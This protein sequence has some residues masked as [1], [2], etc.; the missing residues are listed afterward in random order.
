ML[1]EDPA[2]SLVVF[3]GDNIYPRGLPDSTSAGFAEAARRLDTQVEVPL[4]R[5]VRG[6][7]VPGNHDWDRFGPDGWNAIRRQGARV[8]RLGRGLVR[9][10]P[11]DGCPG[12]AVVDEGTWLRLVLVDTQWWLHG[13]EKPKGARSLCQS[14]DDVA[15]QDALRSAMLSA[16]ERRVVV[17]GHHPLAS[18]GEHGGFFDWKD[19]LFPLR[20]FRPWLLI[21]FP[22]IGSAYPVARGF[23]ISSQ[24]IP[25]GTYQR[26][27]TAFEAA[28]DGVPP[29]VYAAGHDH[30]LQVLEGGAA[31]YQ[32]ISG[33]GIYGHRSP[34]SGMPNTRLAMAEAG[35]MRLDL[36]TDGRVRLGV[37]TVNQAG[38]PTEVYSTW[39]DAA[40]TPRNP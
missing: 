24:D 14:H 1:D 20:H 22:V 7:F 21:P 29:L 2:R 36:L 10:L 5:G 9:L 26:M 30:G 16:G 28:F 32:L 8:E 34:V 27:R 3:M 13:G 39:L 4:T 35:F 38:N 33:A 23:G 31:R 6:I 37:I 25:S 18:G 19:H 12:P 15:M 11:A 40:A 17:V